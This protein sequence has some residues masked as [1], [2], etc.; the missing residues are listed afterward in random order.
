MQ[1]VTAAPPHPLNRQ[2]ALDRGGAEVGEGDFTTPSPL[3]RDGNGWRF[4]G[5]AL[6]SGKELQSPGSAKKGHACTC[7][8]RSPA[9]S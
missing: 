8:G 9:T 6:A 1:L 3:I 4:A 7:G 2:A 5:R